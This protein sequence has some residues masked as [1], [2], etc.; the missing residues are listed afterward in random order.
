[1]TSPSRRKHRITALSTLLSTAMI[2]GLMSSPAATQAADPPQST[3]DRFLKR[4]PDKDW[5]HLK[6]EA[7]KR[8]EAQETERAKRVVRPYVS[9]PSLAPQLPEHNPPQPEPTPHVAP[10]SPAIHSPITPQN[11]QPVRT[12]SPSVI[13]ASY[14]N[15]TSDPKKLKS[16]TSIM[17]YADYMPEGVMRTDIDPSLQKPEEVGLGG[18]MVTGRAMQSTCFQWQASNIYHNP[19]YFEDPAFER[20]GHSWHPVVQPFVSVGRFSTQL[21]GLPYQMA[22]DGPC[23]KMYPL[24]WYRPGDCAPKLIP[25]V[26]WN[27]KA[28]IVQGAATTGAVFAL[29]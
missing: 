4:S 25:Q 18:D 13:E 8:R 16:I 28:A 15:T 27:T 1:M 22:I 5:E 7:R 9:T 23:K 29:P 19:L 11:Y 3:L 17:P 24:G 14:Q 2:A 12:L 6:E 20:Y 10:T 21:V 26:P